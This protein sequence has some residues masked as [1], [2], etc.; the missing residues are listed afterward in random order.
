M[1]N[2][3]IYDYKGNSTLCWVSTL[4]CDIFILLTYGVVKS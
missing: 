1:S 4:Y 3:K 2:L